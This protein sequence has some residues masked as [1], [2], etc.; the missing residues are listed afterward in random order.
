MIGG[1]IYVGDDTS[2]TEAVQEQIVTSLQLEDLTNVNIEFYAKYIANNR[3][4]IRLT[5]CKDVYINSNIGDEEAKVSFIVFEENTENCT[6]KAKNLYITAVENFS[7]TPNK[8]LNTV[9]D[10]NSYTGRNFG[11][12]ITSTSKSIVNGENYDQL[13]FT[14]VDLIDKACSNTKED[15]KIL[16]IPGNTSILTFTSDDFVS[17]DHGIAGQIKPSHIYGFMSNTNP[18]GA[19]FYINVNDGTA[20]NN[21]LESYL[22]K[23]IFHRANVQFYEDTEKYSFYIRAVDSKFKILAKPSA[24]NKSTII[25]ECTNCLVEANYSVTPKWFD[26]RSSNNIRAIL[27]SANATD[28]INLDCDDSYNCLVQINKGVVNSSTQTGSN[29]NLYITKNDRGYYIQTPYELGESV[30][31]IVSNIDPWLN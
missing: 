12:I 22:K 27:N 24:T 6:V 16:Y 26:I 20:S 13:A 25:V 9:I 21:A 18:S 14:K 11:E 28:P 23:M 30:Y 10:D 17:Y 29:S 4:S 7:I 31:P 15:N 1:N 5:N 8:Y 19:A 2:V 3:W